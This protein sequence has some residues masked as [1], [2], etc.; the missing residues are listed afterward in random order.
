MFLGT[1]F[2]IEDKMKPLKHIPSAVLFKGVILVCN[3]QLFA[4]TSCNQNLKYCTGYLI[5]CY[6]A[7]Y[8]ASVDENNQVYVRVLFAHNSYSNKLDYQHKNCK[9]QTS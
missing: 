7:N 8:L 3:G 4:V 1:L 9:Y 2:V 6:L 5:S